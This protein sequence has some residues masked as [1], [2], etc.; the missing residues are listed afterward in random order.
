MYA[1]YC[2][3]CAFIHRIFAVIQWGQLIWHRGW[4][5]WS[6]LPVGM[7]HPA[8]KSR[9]CH[10]LEWNKVTYTFYCPIWFPL[11]LPTTGVA[12]LPSSTPQTWQAVAITQ[13]NS[14]SYYYLLCGIEM[15]RDLCRTEVYA[16]SST[17]REGT[18]MQR[19]KASLGHM[20][21]Q[22]EFQL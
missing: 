1:E 20:P 12:H 11:I 17:S 2:A 10:H 22:T 15:E 8:S 9:R 7:V 14:I 19:L 3:K 5:K 18:P 21:L 4:E 16:P 6:I 13:L